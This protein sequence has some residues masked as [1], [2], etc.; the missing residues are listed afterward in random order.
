[1]KRAVRQT[2]AGY[3]I[4]ETMIFLIISGALMASAAL[5]FNGKINRSQFT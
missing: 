2:E 5:L 4:L 3:T 1:M